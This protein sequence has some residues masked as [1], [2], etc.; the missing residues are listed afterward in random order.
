MMRYCAKCGKEMMDGSECCPTCEE[1]E[2]GIF[3]RNVKN[4]IITNHIDLRKIR[5]RVWIMIAIVFASAVIYAMV[6]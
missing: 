5:P 1:Q 3:N 6:N 4:A 2:S